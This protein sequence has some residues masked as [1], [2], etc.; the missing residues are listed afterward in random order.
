[1]QAVSSWYLVSL[2]YGISLNFKMPLW[3]HY[4]SGGNG[5]EGLAYLLLGTFPSILLHTHVCNSGP[6]PLNTRSPPKVAD[7]L[8]K[9]RHTSVYLGHHNLNI[10]EAFW[11]MRDYVYISVTCCVGIPFLGAPFPWYQP[12]FRSWSALSVASDNALSYPRKAFLCR[13]SHCIGPLD[14]VHKWQVW[15]LTR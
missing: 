7:I 5:A 8:S 1:M 3:Y 4:W 2:K 10:R 12:V 6:F 13:I 14:V 15:I 11:M 9:I